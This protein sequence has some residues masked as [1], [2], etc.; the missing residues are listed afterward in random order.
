MHLPKDDGRRAAAGARAISTRPSARS[1]ELGEKVDTEDD[2]G[3]LSEL[4]VDPQA[5]E[6]GFGGQSPAVG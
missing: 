4:G 1:S 5:L 3:L 2:A 6:D